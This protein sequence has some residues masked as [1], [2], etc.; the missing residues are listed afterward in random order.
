MASGTGGRPKSSS[1]PMILLE[2]QQVS[3]RIV[4]ETCISHPI[5]GIVVVVIIANIIIILAAPVA[6]A[7]SQARDRTHATAVT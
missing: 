6:C 3:G 4:A 2:V 5:V 7:S 1:Q